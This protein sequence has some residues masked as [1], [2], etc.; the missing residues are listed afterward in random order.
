MK[1]RTVFFSYRNVHK[2]ASNKD[3]YNK[4]LVQ[5]KKKNEN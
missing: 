3:D 2:N 4:K 5:I 1:R